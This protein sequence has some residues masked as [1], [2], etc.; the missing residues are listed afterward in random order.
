MRDD[1][2]KAATLTGSEPAG[3]SVASI[4]G[5]D[6][7]HGITPFETET[8]YTVIIACSK[9]AKARGVKNVMKKL[10]ARKRCPDMIFVPQE[11]DLFRRAHNALC[12]AIHS[13]IPIDVR[14]SIDELA[15]RLDR[16]D[17]ADPLGLTSRIKSAITD[18]VGK[19]ITCSIGFG[20]NRHI[21]KIA[22]KMETQWGHHMGT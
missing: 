5:A 14:K 19:H 22:C 4:C 15:C 8:D 12:C 6:V 10:E 7:R 20:P 1:R 2:I 11:P 13:V 16:N 3:A 9:E 18:D 21:A 17:I